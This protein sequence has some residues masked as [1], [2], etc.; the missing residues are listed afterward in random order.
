[1][2]A[3]Q[4]VMRRIPAPLAH[5]VPLGGKTT[6]VVGIL[7]VTPDSFSDGGRW[8]DPHSAIAHG[9]NM[10]DEGALMVDVGGESTRPGAQRVPVEEEWRRV[11]RVISALVAKGATVSID[12]VN[13]E[14]AR[15]AVLEGA[16]VVNDVSGGCND[17]GTVKVAAQ[18]DTAFVVQH[19]RGFPSD[20]NLNQQY[21]DVVG[22]VR[23]ELQ[24]QVAQALDLGL[25]AQSIIVDP[26]LGFAK[27]A[28]D[29]WMLATG[30][31][32]F[33]ETGFPVLVGA[34]RK[35]FVAAR[36]REDLD[37]GTLEV[38]R[39]AVQAGAWAVRVHNVKQNV[40][41]IETLSSGSMR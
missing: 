11:G 3:T 25:S 17:P 41:L 30:L 13:A 29:S 4:S 31:D 23:K 10:M 20:P 38:T 7:N 14:T 1:M 22:Q 8:F 5:G 19:W 32:H 2:A 40:R 15:R 39:L 33:V 37:S 6:S 9:L 34:S 12:T 35:R 21:D 16:C 28:E 18:A 24:A 26:G 36:Y 27:E